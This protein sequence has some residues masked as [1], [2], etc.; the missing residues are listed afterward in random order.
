M[1]IL[2]LLGRHDFSDLGGIT[3]DGEPLKSGVEICSHCQRERVNELVFA[4]FN[5]ECR[6]TVAS[7]GL[8][9]ARPSERLRAWAARPS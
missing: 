3:Y 8:P 4:F 2:C 9:F 7:S 1:R 6:A 5:L